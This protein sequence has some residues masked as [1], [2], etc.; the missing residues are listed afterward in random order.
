DAVS[1]MVGAY[2]CGRPA[3]LTLYIHSS[4]YHN[5]L[6]QNL[7]LIRVIHVPVESIKNPIHYMN[8]EWDG[9]F[10]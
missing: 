1:C 9:T 3:A 4:S 7:W 5:L 10:P 6:S 8:K 2:P